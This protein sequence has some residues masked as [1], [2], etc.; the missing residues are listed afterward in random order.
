MEDGARGE[1]DTTK[2]TGTFPMTSGSRPAFIAAVALKLSTLCDKLATTLGG[3]AE[4]THRN[5]DEG[6]PG[7][8]NPGRD[9]EWVSNRVR[10]NGK[11]Q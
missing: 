5:V 10:I 3:G 8:G 11:E 2:V 9:I 1:V 7:N 6:P 4:I